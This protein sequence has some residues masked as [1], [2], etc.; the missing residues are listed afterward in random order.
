[1]KIFG[2]EMKILGSEMKILGSKEACV[3]RECTGMFQV[4]EFRV[5][6]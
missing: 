3:Q 4:A 5:C 6:R 1:M 2:S